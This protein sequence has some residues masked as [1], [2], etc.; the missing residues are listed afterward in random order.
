MDNLDY[1]CME[2]GQKVPEKKEDESLITKALGVLQENG[3]YAMFLF[4]REKK[5]KNTTKEFAG[6][7]LNSLIGLLNDN[8]IKGFFG[9]APSNK[10]PPE[11]I[12]EWLIGI[13]KDIDK[14]FFLK[15]ILEQTLVYAR[16]YSKALPEEGK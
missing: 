6:K 11:K 14:L 7:C 12:S 1:L 9:S 13:S 5:N 15:K 3:P 16:Y 10:Q 2:Y 4:L 8:E